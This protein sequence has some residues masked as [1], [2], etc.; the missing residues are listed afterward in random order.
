MR[1]APT[2]NNWMTPLSS[3]AM[4]E[5]FA[6]FKMA[7]WSAPVFSSAFSRAVGRFARLAAGARNAACVLIVL[8]RGCRRATHEPRGTISNGDAARNM[9]R[10]AVF[11]RRGR[12]GSEA[13]RKNGIRPPRRFAPNVLRGD[14]FE[15]HESAHRNRRPG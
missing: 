8:L 6:L 3:V 15:N 2:L 11:L 7:F 12:L 10:E 5:K 9:S 14:S 4:L 1:S 13:A